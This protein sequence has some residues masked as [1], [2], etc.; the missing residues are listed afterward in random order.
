MDL[1]VGSKHA[2]AELMGCCELAT[3]FSP[4][5]TV[6]EQCTAVQCQQLHFKERTSKPKVCHCNGFVSVPYL[7]SMDTMRQRA[8]CTRIKA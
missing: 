1:S 8:C 5:A 7:Q 2:A 3:I 4:T 6:Q